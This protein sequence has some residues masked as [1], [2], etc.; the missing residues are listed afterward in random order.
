[1]RDE[2]L[3][4]LKLVLTDFIYNP[5][6]QRVS[7]LDWPARAHSMI[8]LRRLDNIQVCAAEVLANDI[9]GDF[10][11]TGV[12]RGGATIFMRALLK[13]YGEQTRKVWVADSFEGLPAPDSE[14][15]PV[16]KN[17]PHHTY[18]FLAVSVE[19]VAQNFARY[20]LLDGQVKFLKGWFA[21]SLPAAPID[22]LALLRLDGDMY[23][24]TWDALTNLYPKLSPGG[25]II[26][27]DYALRGCKAAVDDFRALNGIQK[28]F[29]RVD[30]TGIFWRKE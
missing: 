3:T 2:Y 27:D 18:K 22:K 11:E 23:G 4:L 1:M 25:Y 14:K 15:Y 9:P 10:M 16:D 12:W 29:E 13:A 8:G 7:G 20:G 21:E 6:E 24:S 28:P 5:S 30:W 17:D 26:I 19:E